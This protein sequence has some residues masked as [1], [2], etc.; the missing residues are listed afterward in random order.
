[1]S[2]PTLDVLSVYWKE[3]LLPLA[4]A[5][6]LGDGDITTR[7][8]LSPGAQ[9]R[10]RIEAKDELVLCGLP[11]LD[12]VFEQLGGVHRIKHL[13]RDGQLVHRGEAV[14]EIEGDLATLLSGERVALNML[15]RLSGVASK[16]ASFTKALD[17]TKIK[18]LDTRKTLPGMRLLEKYAVKIGGGTNHRIGLFDL[19]LIKDNHISAC[20]GSIAEAVKRV[21]Q[22]AQM[23]GAPTLDIEVE[24]KTLEQVK[25]A[26]AQ[27]VDIIMLDNM[28]D[29]K[30]RQ[31]IPLVARQAKIEVSGNVT[32]GR[33]P[34]LARL[35]IDYISCGAITHSAPAR[36][37]S[38]NFT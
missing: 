9:A 5:E 30:L 36:D 15:Q 19:Y 38:M 1:M 16:T 4:L 24:C 17:G 7:A 37:L 2:L 35:E 12:T 21:R 10:A 20:G 14:W 3:K 32:L 26:V 29:L 13:A 28:D 34:N 18:L 22:H 25:E 31:A 11:F 6:D 33:L 27:H 23:R 8:I